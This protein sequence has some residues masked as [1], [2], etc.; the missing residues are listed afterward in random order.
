MGGHAQII[1]PDSIPL[2]KPSTGHAT[3]SSMN[4]EPIKICSKCGAEYS[5]QAVGCADCGGDLVF[6]QQYEKATV[7]REEAE[8]TV[9]VRQGPAS[10]LREL[11]ALLKQDG[12]PSDIQFH[13]S[14][15]GT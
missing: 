6:P 1:F 15:P 9:L 4:E 14:P 2:D 13:G 10:Y 11:E 8:A 7:P 12:I 3:I 5:L